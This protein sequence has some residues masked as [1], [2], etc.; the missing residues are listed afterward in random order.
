MRNFLASSRSRQAR[1]PDRA[2]A[3]QAAARHALGQR[4]ARACSCRPMPTQQQFGDVGLSKLAPPAVRRQ[5]ALRQADRGA[6]PGPRAGWP[7]AGPAL[8]YTSLAAQ[9]GGAGGQHVAGLPGHAD[10]VRPVPRP[11]VRPLEA[12]GFLGL[13]PR[14]SPACNGSGRGRQVATFDVQDVEQGE[15]KLPGTEEVVLP[16]FLGGDPSSD[17]S[18]TTRRERLVQWLTW[19]ENPFVARAAVN[20]VWAQM[21]GRGL[22]DPV[23][24]LGEHNPPSHR[25]LLDELAA[26]FVRTRLRPQ[27]PGADAGRHAGL[28]AIE[29]DRR[30]RARPARAVRP[31]GDQKPDRR[32]ALRLPDRSDAAAR[33]PRRRPIVRGGSL[34]NRGSSSWPSSAPDAGADR[35]PGG[36]SAGA[37]A[38]ERPGHRAGHRPGAEATCSPPSTRRSSPTS[39]EWKCCSSRPSRAHPIKA[40]AAYLWAMLPVPP[41]A[42]TAAAP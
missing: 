2:A 14:S 3:G 7:S 36:R 37:H 27:P 29:P 8:F 28:P 20:R 39:G 9:A 1:Q 23:D 31:D 34:T 22:V 26:Y 15:V 30:R 33:E 5:R 18:V 16:R 4:V 38:D 35:V 6:D 13:T 42:L 25:E 40:N 19:P 11:P 17:E 12:A 21:F 41:T 10:S 32:A 24:D